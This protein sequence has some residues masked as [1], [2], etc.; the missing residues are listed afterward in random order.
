MCP[1]VQ[2]HNVLY[3][4]VETAHAPLYTARA[5]VKVWFQLMHEHIY[6]GLKKT[7]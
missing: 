4:I 5:Y 2:R 3:E 6:V 7:S 1:I